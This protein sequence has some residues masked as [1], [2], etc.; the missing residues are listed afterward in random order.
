MNIRRASDKTRDRIEWS[1]AVTIQ[2][3]ARKIVE[4]LLDGL[5]DLTFDCGLDTIEL[6]S[7]LRRVSISLAVK[8]QLRTGERLSI[9]RVSAVTG[10]SRAEISN[11]LKSEART[12]SKNN[13]N[14]SVLNR[15]L[16]AWRMDVRF[17]AGRRPKALK[18]FGRGASFESLA[19]LYGRGLPIRA[20]FDELISIGAIELL[21][22]QIV[23]LKK[24][25]AVGE[26]VTRKNIEALR[27]KVI[28]LFGH[29]PRDQI[30]LEGRTGS[31]QRR[32]NLKRV[33]SKN[34]GV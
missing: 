5:L 9:S 30:S 34:R 32:R 33:G 17:L 28:E 2:V 20:I 13:P 26:S 31:Y 1:D 22:S 6:M 15:I 24:P 3:S 16:S 8:R 4:Q 19:K 11:L 21:P 7:T 27:A 29:G 23:V 14:E 18:L 25:F 10:I 12:E